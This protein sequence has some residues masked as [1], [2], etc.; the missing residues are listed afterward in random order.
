MPIFKVNFP[1]LK[2]ENHLALFDLARLGNIY[3]KIG[4]ELIDRTRVI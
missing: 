1:D 4:K 3:E 2:D